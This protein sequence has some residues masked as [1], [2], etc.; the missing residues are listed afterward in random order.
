MAAQ[1][2]MFPDVPGKTV[3]LTEREIREFVSNGWLITSSTFD[4]SS[5][6]ATSYDV[7][8][9]PRGIIGGQG[10]EIDLAKDPLVIGPGAYAGIV[11]LEKV[12]LPKNVFAQVG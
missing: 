2:Q 1:A 12:K 3:V 7:R 6:E 5:L 10:N 9:G 8:V 4:E 11:S